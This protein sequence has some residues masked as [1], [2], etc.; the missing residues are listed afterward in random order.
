[1]Q[2][3]GYLLTASHRFW[4]F[5][6]NL[7]SVYSSAL[8]VSE[9]LFSGGAA[10]MPQ[11]SAAVVVA[12]YPCNVMTSPHHQSQSSALLAAHRGVGF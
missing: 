8:S 3:N 11:T 12:A 9:L 5:P 6:L 7:L 4:V 2:I 10:L 1:M